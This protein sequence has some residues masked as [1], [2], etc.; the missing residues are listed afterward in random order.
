MNNHH[1]YLA[2]YI[3]ITYASGESASLMPSLT[4]TRTPLTLMGNGKATR[5][6]LEPAQESATRV[7]MPGFSGH[8]AGFGDTFIAEPA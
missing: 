1:R 7:T 4:H 5:V 3:R 8:R 2:K 6:N